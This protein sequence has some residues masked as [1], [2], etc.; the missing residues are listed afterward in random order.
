[1]GEF[2]LLGPAGILPG[3]VDETILVSD[4]YVPSS[5]Q[6]RLA[7]RQITDRSRPSSLPIAA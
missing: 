2:M 7:S 5:Q 4:G 6:F 3:I 1:M